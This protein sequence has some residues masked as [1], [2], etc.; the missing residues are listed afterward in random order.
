M[1]V[2][3]YYRVSSMHKEQQNSFEAQSSHYTKYIKNNDQWEFFRIYSDE[4]ISGTKKEIRP[5][6]M[7]AV[8]NFVYE[9]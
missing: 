6:F 5:E 2:Y 7:D 8:N 4:G 1:R 9:T 3:A